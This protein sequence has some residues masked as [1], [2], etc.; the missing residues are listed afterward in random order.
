VYIGTQSGLYIETYDVR[1]D[2]HY[3]VYSRATPGVRYYF[4]VAALGTNAVPGPRSAEVT[5]VARFVRSVAPAEG[6]ASS[7]TGAADDSNVICL[8]PYRADC[9]SVSVLARGAGSLSSLTSLGNG[10]LLYIEDGRRVRMVAGSTLTAEPA[11]EAAPAARFTGLAVDPDY[12]R[13][14]RVFVAEVSAGRAGTSEMRIVRFRELG[15]RLG[16]GAA[17]V[18]GLP[19]PVPGH[20]PF[21]VGSSQ[22][23]YV[24][25]PAGSDGGGL[26]S[27]STGSVLRFTQDGA[28]AAGNRSGSPVLSAGYGMP[29]LVLWDATGQQLWVAGMTAQAVPALGQVAPDAAAS[30]DWPTLPRP[31]EMTF[32][33]SGEVP[34]VTSLATAAAGQGGQVFLTDSE[35]RLY[36]GAPRG[37]ALNVLEIPV[38]PFGS[39]IGVTGGLD[40]PLYVAVRTGPAAGGEQS[41]ALLALQRLPSDVIYSPR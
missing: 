9:Y 40:E 20:A 37:A 27:R 2:Q 18:Y 31:V 15:G 33:G 4:A 12:A 41:F 32:D 29:S 34:M 17:V 14:G 30:Q 1:R 24:A 22:D 35:G 21:S 23:V 16:E 36:R 25:L 13:N 38:G 11:L 5:G 26:S 10:R 28:A 3:F 19:L 7:R 39:A 8:D 6:T